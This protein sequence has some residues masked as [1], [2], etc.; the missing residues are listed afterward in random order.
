[1]GT[2]QACAI[3]PVTISYEE[4]MAY[5][6]CVLVD[7]RTRKAY[8]QGHA[9]EAANID[10][11]SIL[12][13]PGGDA[14]LGKM[15]GRHGIGP[16][17]LAVFYDDIHGA[18]AARAALALES[19]GGRASLLDQTYAAWKANRNDCGEPTGTPSPE[20]VAFEPHEPPA[21]GGPL[22]GID[23]V[24]SAAAS[25]D[26]DGAVIIID[27][28]DRLHYLSGHIPGAISMPSAMFRDIQND[29]ILLPPGD[30]R[31]LF[32]NRGITP[33]GRVGVIAYCGS[34]GTLSGVVYYALKHAGFDGIK[35][36]SNSFREWDTE[37]GRDVEA[38]EDANYW[39]LSAE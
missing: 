18:V 1:M 12:A 5:D 38:Q 20:P 30:L 2:T 3:D 7:A 11:H 9:P 22:A 19:I 31:R 37:L 15:F 4:S 29:K 10:L 27:A 23:A 26:T 28:R 17:T 36:Y 39:D 24:D 25:G 33:G 14:G 16:E 32:E 34:A 13:A 21:G 8:E 6:D 35:I